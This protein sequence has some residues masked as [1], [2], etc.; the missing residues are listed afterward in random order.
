MAVVAVVHVMVN[1][2][3]AV[4]AYPLVA[5]LEWRAYKRGDLALDELARKI[6][7]V[8]FIVTTT[9][10]ALT[11]VG[12]WLTAALIAPFGIGSLLRVFFWAWFT[13]WLVFITEVVLVLIYFLAW[14]RWA[15][16]RWKKVHIGVGVALGVMSWFTMAIIVAI[17]GFMMGTGS[18]TTD[19]SF[20]SA[21]LNPLYVPQLA[22]RTTFA[23]ITAGLFVW[24][25][26][27][28]FTRNDRTLRDGTVRVIATWILVL[29]PF[30]I[31]AAVWYW[32]RVP[33]VL[34]AN[35]NVGLLT[36]AFVNW[37][38][39]FLIV[40]G[41]ATG[42]LVLTAII[43]ALRPGAIPRFLLIIPF[44][45]G[46]YLLGHFERAREFLRKP[47]VVAD[48]MYSNGVTMDELPIFQRD[49]ILRYATYVRHRRV[50]EANRLEAG[51]DV[52]MLS[53]S[54][55]HTTNG[56]NG[57]V[58]RF[59]VLYG[60]QPWDPA[61][62]SAFVESMHL[63]RT[64]MPPFPGNAAEREA[65]VTYVGSLQANPVPILGVQT[66]GLDVP[67]TTANAL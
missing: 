31:A 32:H 9:V 25:L 63:T 30:W 35:L 29:T 55:C 40:V 51:Q 58:K 10:G 21:I 27:F 43:A 67:D 7:F 53:C 12:I 52:F 26:L 14:R 8:L 54:R 6:T 56:V 60:T 17:L 23:L 3:I 1:H 44:I 36:Q 65:L 13:E 57:V 11:G 46:L 24:F 42:L 22:F 20:F 50:T 16:G 61:A 41:I 37:E 2:P 4:G 49:G 33:A 28:F 48:Y 64:F 34:A 19:H 45:F 59:T 66:E 15:I 38:G 18:W 39:T 5:M 47:H 62:L